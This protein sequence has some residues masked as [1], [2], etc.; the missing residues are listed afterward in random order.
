[1]TASGWTG[2]VSQNK[3]LRD[4]RC[5]KYTHTWLVSRSTHRERGK[6]G[7]VVLLYTEVFW[8]PFW[9]RRSFMQ[10]SCCPPSRKKPFW[11]LITTKKHFNWKPTSSQARAPKTG[12]FY[13]SLVEFIQEASIDVAQAGVCGPC[14]RLIWH[15]LQQRALIPLISCI[16]P[17]PVQC[18]L[19]W[20][21]RSF[22]RAQQPPLSSYTDPMCHPPVHGVLAAVPGPHLTWDSLAKESSIS[23]EFLR[24]PWTASPSSV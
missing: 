12:L 3:S 10:F 7:C 21:T 13:S 14:W 16:R 23:A 17:A 1:M 6:V 2:L 24:G 22:P 4:K 19:L 9:W 15:H 11:S 18:A 20:S 5:S 8:L